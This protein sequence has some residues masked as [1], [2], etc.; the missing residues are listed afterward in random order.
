[1]VAAVN[2][3]ELMQLFGG[4]QELLAAPATVVARSLLVLEGRGNADEERARRAKS[5]AE[6]HGR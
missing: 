1:M 4:Y 6:N 2:E 3:F 5:E